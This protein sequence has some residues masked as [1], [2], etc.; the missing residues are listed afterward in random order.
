MAYT[1]EHKWNE[2]V[3][4]SETQEQEQSKQ[5][6]NN[7]VIS[8]LN[9]L[10]NINN[11]TTKDFFDNAFQKMD[12]KDIKLS[13]FGE[14]CINKT[15]VNISNPKIY[16]FITKPWYLD[17]PKNFA[18]FLSI[19]DKNNESE[20]LD[21]TIKEKKDINAEKKEVLA[22]SETEKQVLKAQ[23][24]ALKYIQTLQSQGKSREECIK[25]AKAKYPKVDI[26]KALK[27]NN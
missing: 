20:E 17:N 12:D 4:D 23:N 9:D 3:L 2:I 16:E 18:T 8:K 13:Q 15:L 10:P 7:L 21:N 11:Q 26:E 22:K 14:N 24:E 6:L 25:M 27:V 19:L 1:F 5:N